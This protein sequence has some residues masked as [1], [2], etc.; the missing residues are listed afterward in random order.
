MP[1]TISI[2]NQKERVTTKQ[3][4][5]IIL[6]LKNKLYRFALSFSLSEAD[7]KDAVQDVMLK[8]WEKITDIDA[9]KNIEAWCMTMVKNRSLDKLRKKGRHYE[10]LD[11]QLSLE[12]KTP[13]PLQVTANN[14]IHTYI[15]TCISS[16]PDRQRDV[17][18]LRD[19]EGHT[20]KEICDIL[21]IEMNQMKVLLHRGRQALRK[22]LEIHY[23]QSRHEK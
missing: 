20:Y 19:I 4:K 12:S 7:A 1:T 23:K 10:D 13:T 14:E 5:E 2:I 22:K 16:L 9:I 21:D 3:F 18:I 17:I 8:S 15:N 11:T 6:P